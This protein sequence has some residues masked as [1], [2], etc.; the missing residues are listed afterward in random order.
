MPDAVLVQG[1]TITVLTGALAAKKWDL[2]VGHIEAG[3]RSHD[4]SMPEEVNRILT[5]H[6]SEF[7]F[8]P[9]KDAIKNV[10]LE[11]LNADYYSMT[12]NTVVDAVQQSIKIVDRKSDVLKKLKLTSKRYIL[13]TT[14]RAENTN[15]KKR[16][17]GIL[18]G[19]KLV[20]DNYPEYTL[21]FSMHPRTKKKIEEY[22]LK[23]SSNIRVM[24]PVGFLEFLQLEKNAKLVITDSGGLQEEC[25]VL[26]VPVVT[27]RDNTERPESMQ[28]G[29]NILAGADPEKILSCT[30][31][32][33][34]RK[35][36]WTSVF[37][38]GHTG[39]R[40]IDELV[41]QLKKRKSIKARAKWV[42]RV[43]RKNLT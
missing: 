43:L 3:L 18:E 13:L 20:A 24:E 28:A 35:I 23:L 8:C 11:G 33:L 4:M 15:D 25:S 37:G 2:P 1:D 36:R 14:H 41:E 26:Q 10:K 16:L 5:D 40:I 30:K 38:D 42:G 32:M 39:E 34:T 19:F 6:I 21:L 22:G 9:T 7:L 31:T 27:V 17:R 29:M 12:G